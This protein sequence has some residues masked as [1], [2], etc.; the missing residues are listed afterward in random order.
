M[1]SNL[2]L[3]AIL[4]SNTEGSVVSLEREDAN[5]RSFEAGSANSQ[6][7]SYVLPQGDEQ[8]IEYRI[9]FSHASCPV[10]ADQEQLLK[11]CLPQILVQSMPS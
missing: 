9:L 2:A 3:Y 7:K 1:Q 5:P 10:G 11:I 8:I 6:M 4:E